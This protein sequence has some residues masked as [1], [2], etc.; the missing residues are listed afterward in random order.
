MVPGSKAG[1]VEA[2]HTTGTSP[3]PV[4]ATPKQAQPAA[5][6]AAVPVG[7][8]QPA[9]P[10]S[11]VA[12]TQMQ[13]STTTTLPG[14]GR[15]AQGSQGRSGAT[16]SMGLGAEVRV[17]AH[18]H[19]A[20]LGAEVRALATAQHGGKAQDGASDGARSGRERPGA[21]GAAPAARGLSAPQPSADVVAGQ[22]SAAVSVSTASGGPGAGPLLGSGVGMQEMID[23]IRGTIDLA[24][25]QGLTQARIALQP[26][27]L[28]QIRIHLSQTADG[29]LARVTADTP[30]AAQALA[31]GRSELHQSLS[32]L[33]LPLLR[34][35]IGSF[36]HSQTSDREDRFTGGS[37]GSG[38]P[39]AAAASAV[40]EDAESAAST[41]EPDVVAGLT[42]LASGGLV[43]V[44]A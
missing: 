38:G 16:P 39:G 26:A 42:G 21:A 35:D 36:G 11:R 4:A 43:D 1:G 15:D 18:A 9:P 3:S 23:A 24:A 30:A 29:L 28:G 34:L 32:S 12:V 17:L 41:G 37:D 2:L 8:A 40:S 5:G 7:S 14:Q 6:T 20:G 10:S 22:A 13:S 31:Q 44:L 33:G 27:E 25:R 19:S